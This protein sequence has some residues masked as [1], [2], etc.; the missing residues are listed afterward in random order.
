MMRLQLLTLLHLLLLVSSEASKGLQKHLLRRLTADDLFE[1]LLSS[2]EM[3]VV[4]VQSKHGLNKNVSTGYKIEK[5]MRSMSNRPSNIFRLYHVDIA[6]KVLD[7]R[8]NLVSFGSLLSKSLAEAHTPCLLLW[9]WGLKSVHS[10]IPLSSS[11]LMTL[12]GT[13]KNKD[14][15]IRTKLVAMLESFVP[16]TKLKQWN[17]MQQPSSSSSSPKI[18][19]K[20]SWIS[21]LKKNRKRTARVVLSLPS[22]TKQPPAWL[23]RLSLLYQ[24]R[25]EFRWRL[26]E[27]EKIQGQKNENFSKFVAD[28]RLLHSKILH[29]VPTRNL[30]SFLK[31]SVANVNVKR[32]RTQQEFQN[33]CSSS[34]II[35]FFQFG[36][37]RGGDELTSIEMLASKSFARV[38]YGERGLSEMHVERAPVQFGWMMASQQETL[39]RQLNLIRTPCLVSLN[40]ISKKYMVHQN[41]IP[42]DVEKMYRFVKSLLS[43]QRQVTRW[44]GDGKGGSFTSLVDEETEEKEPMDVPVWFEQHEL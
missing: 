37:K 7:T 24:E 13:K 15:K 22:S 3:T 6:E 17:K 30:T 10:P 11:T 39:V 23:K 8:K 38:S 36:D 43:G 14:K 29:Q 34:C 25:V 27:S 26:H 32:I 20:R 21:W 42:M 31:E 44:I 2:D 18:K 28:V 12:I 5:A 35:G 33:L 9:Q 1:N 40:A 19:K 41:R 16:F 4:L